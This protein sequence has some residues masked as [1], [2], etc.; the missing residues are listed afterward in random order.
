MNLTPV[1]P[2]GIDPIEF[3]L[4]NGTRICSPTGWLDAF[5]QYNLG[6]LILHVSLLNMQEEEHH[7]RV[8]IRIFEMIDYG[9]YEDD[10]DIARRVMPDDVLISA[11]GRE[12]FSYMF[13]FLGLFPGIYLRSSA[14]SSYYYYQ[15]V[16]YEDFRFFVDRLRVEHPTLFTTEW[17]E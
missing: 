8:T 9:A 17:R 4:T 5:K 2:L 10:E 16:P 13:H 12:A 11:L 6:P 7:V 15:N 14:L 1:I 3:I